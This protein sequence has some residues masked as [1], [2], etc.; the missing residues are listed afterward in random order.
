MKCKY[1]YI[2]IDADDTLFDFGAAEAEAL[3]KVFANRG[4]ALTNEL[5]E[6]YRRINRELWNRF[7]R[8]E[9]NKEEIQSRRF[10][11]LFSAHGVTAVNADEFNYDYLGFLGESSELIDGAYELCETLSKHAKLA[12]VTN[13]IART[14]E[15]RFAASGLDKFIE[16]VFVSENVGYAK[17]DREYF[18][19]VFFR[20]GIEYKK[21]ALIVGDSLAS[22]IK[23]GADYGM[24]TCWFNL[25]GKPNNSDYT[26]VYEISRLTIL[27]EHIMYN[28]K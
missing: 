19:Y 12:V 28:E 3:S 6:D 23:G 26:P 21:D 27:F 10:A 13:G 7:E 8:R 14:Q 4:L 18:D 20:M 17:P 1:K 16:D 9:I 2:L 15:K 5:S 24:D 22:D 11:E 25:S